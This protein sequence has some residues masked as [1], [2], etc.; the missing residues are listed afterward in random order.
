MH[1]RKVIAAAVASALALPMGAQAVEFAVSGH[2]NRAVIVVDQDE[3]KKDRPFL[4]D[5]D[6][7]HVDSNAS[8]TRFRFKGSE[9]LGGMTAGVTLELGRP[10]NWRTRQAAVNLSGEFGTLTLGHTGEAADG[11]AHADGAFNGGSWLAGVSN[12]CAYA[13]SGPACPSN[14]GDR[15]DVLKYDTPALGPAKVSVSTGND[16]RWSTQLKVAG[17]AGDA[18]YD[19]RIG[20]IAK[21]ET[22]TH[23]AAKAAS[24]EHDLG[25]NREDRVPGENRVPNLHKETSPTMATTKKEEDGDIL[26]TSV[27]VNFGQGTTVGAAWSKDEIPGKP[28][29]HEYTYLMVDQSYGDG[30]IGAYWKQGEQGKTEGT[31]WGVGIGHSIGGGATAYAGFRHVEADGADDLNLYL[32]GMR[33]T[34]N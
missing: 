8:E 33:V 13:G 16:E 25:A 4:K 1:E 19:F 18:G 20:Y 24:L 27:A 5:G 28:D 23:V 26:T 31:L 10:G 21:F 2:I 12:W 11:M 3:E 30:S 15:I 34:F 22:E 32:A 9:D 29:E 7:Q 6:L 14:D 17:S